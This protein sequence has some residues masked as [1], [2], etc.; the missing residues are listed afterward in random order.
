MHR[1][2][3]ELRDARGDVVLIAVS[4]VDMGDEAT[5]RGFHRVVDGSGTGTVTELSRERGRY[6]SVRL[7][8]D[9]YEP[10]CEGNVVAYAQAQ[11]V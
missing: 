5:A 9:I 1:A 7:T 8:G 6:R 11:P 4:W 3:F 2:L 10:R